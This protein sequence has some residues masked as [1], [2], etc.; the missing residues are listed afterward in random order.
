MCTGLEFLSLKGQGHFYFAKCISL[1]TLKVNGKSLKV[2]Q[3]QDQSNGERGL[4]GLSVTQGQGI[5]F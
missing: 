1:E 3:G 5:T 2:H 4:L